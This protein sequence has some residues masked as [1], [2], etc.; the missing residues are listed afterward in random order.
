MDLWESGLPPTVT[1]SRYR[2]RVTP[3]IRNGKVPP[4]RLSNA[5]RRPREYLTPDEVELLITTAQKRVGARTPH[6]DATMILL[7]CRHGLRASELCS[8]RWDML[9]L[10]QGRYHVTRR[11]NG[12]PSVHLLRGTEI[13]A[14]RRLQ[15][16]QVPQ[17]S[18]V[19]TTERRGP[20]TPAT[21][22]KLL[23]T[24][25]ET[26]GLPFPSIR[27]CCGTP[28]ATSSRTTDT[29]P[30][31]CRSGSGT[32]TSRTPRA[33]PSSRAEGSKISGSRRIDEPDERRSYLKICTRRGQ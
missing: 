8:L 29:T 30:A 12:R 17:G 21:F 6:R 33:T 19:F 2:D 11:K 28:A 27:T 20:M 1:R 32:R 4:R 31:P 14:L 15:R 13:R 7:T 3:N 10:A 23:T 16:E 26:A 9:D 25:G 24:L 5:E 22:R 18:D